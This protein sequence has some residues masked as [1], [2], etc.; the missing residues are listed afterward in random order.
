MCFRQSDPQELTEIY[1]FGDLQAVPLDYADYTNKHQDIHAIKEDRY[2]PGTLFLM[3]GAAIMKYTPGQPLTHFLGDINQTDYFVYE[4]GNSSVAKFSIIFDLVQYNRTKIAL[5]DYVNNCVREYDYETD[6]V[7]PLFGACHSTK[8]LHRIWRDGDSI[9][10]D[11][12]FLNGVIAVEFIESDNY[13]IAID[14]GIG[15]L[16]VF[17]VA[18]QQAMPLLHRSESLKVSNPSSLLINKNG[19]QLYVSH[20]FGLSKIDLNSRYVSLLAGQVVSE[21]THQNAPL[22]AEP[23]SSG[24]V[25]LMTH[26]SWIVADKVLVGKGENNSG[27]V[28]VNPEEQI[29]S[30]SCKGENSHFETL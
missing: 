6:I 27:V 4:E 11:H 15:Q 14:K 29:V 16:S 19:N 28:I 13:F 3:I 1:K 26:L 17:D 24:L 21:V 23:F 22:V 20:K 8:P 5:A 7:Q 30:A 2:N 25:E 10:G 9:P 18:S 12:H